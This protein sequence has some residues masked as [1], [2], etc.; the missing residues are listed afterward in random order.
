M[1]FVLNFLTNVI[2]LHLF[3]YQARGPLIANPHAVLKKILSKN[4]FCSRRKEVKLF[5]LFKT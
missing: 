5:T 1:D 2:G 4:T 3:L